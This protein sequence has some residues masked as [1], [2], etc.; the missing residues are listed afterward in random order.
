MPVK[1]CDIS[2]MAQ[3]ENGQHT[4]CDWLIISAVVWITHINVQLKD[5]Y[6]QKDDDLESHLW[7][8]YL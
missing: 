6:R 5:L 4:I 7:K 1:Q 8:N 2:V 3:W